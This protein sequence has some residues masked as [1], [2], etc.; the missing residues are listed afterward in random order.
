MD[1]HDGDLRQDIRNE[2]ERESGE[3]HGRRTRRLRQRSARVVHA[4]LAGNVAIALAK[5]GAY[6]M[7][8]SSGMLT[9]AIHSVIDSIDQLLLLLG[10]AR[11]RRPADADHPLGHGMEVYF[12]SFVVAIM[13]FLMG[14]IASIYHGIE[15]VRVP[16]PVRSPGIGFGV[17]AAAAC[18]DAL[19]LLVGVRE[20]KRLVR[21]RKVG[22]WTFIRRSKDP[23]LYASLLEDFAGLAGVALAALGLLG[24][25]AFR[26]PTADG[27]ASIAIGLLLAAVAVVLANE[28]R[29][30][31]AGEAVSPAL[32]A[33]I[34]RLLNAD[35]RV[36]A[37]RDIATLHLG[38][39]AVLVALTLRFKSNMTM[40][41]LRDTVR[42]LTAAMQEADDRIAHVYVRPAPR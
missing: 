33:E 19:S 4:A 10:Q 36:V 31:I 2:A 7:S 40:H 37:V 6:G 17:L 3:A 32:L 25:T 15:R 11:G 28:T 14:G 41:A 8:R 12:W 22:P 13:V 30:L 39:H 26:V 35:P 18:F 20:Y 27:I 23:S 9:E 5:L 34:R 29:S 1:G 38:P 16:E 24:A 42:D 21:G